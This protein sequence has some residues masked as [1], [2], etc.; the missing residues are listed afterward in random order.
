MYAIL[1]QS[2][3]MLHLKM[4][5]ELNQPFIVLWN[6]IWFNSDFKTGSN[7]DSKNLSTI[8]YCLIYF[9]RLWT[10]TERTIRYFLLKQIPRIL[11]NFYKLFLENQSWQGSENQTY[12]SFHR[13]KY[14]GIILHFIL[15]VFFSLKSI[16]S[17]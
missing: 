13:C 12:F 2:V 14:F 6:K 3:P 8:I 11:W 9:F 1:A 10:K 16:L 17:M 4:E 7:F 15:Y 5:N